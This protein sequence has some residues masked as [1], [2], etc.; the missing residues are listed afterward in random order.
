[1]AQW[2]KSVVTKVKEEYNLWNLH[3]VT[4]ELKVALWSPQKGS[5]YKYIFKKTSSLN[6][7]DKGNNTVSHYSTKTDTRMVNAALCYIS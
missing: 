4:K 5:K 6:C 3:I 7:F 1:M 2:E